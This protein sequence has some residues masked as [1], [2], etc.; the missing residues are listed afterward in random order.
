M[1]R[2]RAGCRPAAASVSCT[3]LFAVASAYAQVDAKD[4]S[5]K[6]MQQIHQAH[7]QAHTL[8]HTHKYTHSHILPMGRCNL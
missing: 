4:F 1:G 2:E 7:T 8:A 3:C 6:I 5:T